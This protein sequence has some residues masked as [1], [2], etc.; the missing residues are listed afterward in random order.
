MGRI[1]HVLRESGLK[2]TVKKSLRTVSR[3]GFSGK[4][5]RRNIQTFID[6]CRSQDA[7]GCTLFMPGAIAVG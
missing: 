3:Y 6:I 4:K 7:Q 2:L 5:M 1:S